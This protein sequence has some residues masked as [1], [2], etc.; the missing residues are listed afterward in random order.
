MIIRPNVKRGFTLIELIV[1]VAIIAVLVAILLPSLGKAREQAKRV[2][3][4]A[5]LRSLALMENIYA[6]TYNN[7]VPRSTDSSFQH[8]FWAYLYAK[9][10]G[11]SVPGDDGIGTATTF[12][13]FYKKLKWLRCPSFPQPSQP[14]CFISNVF[15]ANFQERFYVNVDKVG[16]QGQVVNCIEVCVKMPATAFGT[17]DLWMPGHIDTSPG[18]LQVPQG[19]QGQCRILADLRH[20][21]HVNI[22]FYDAHVETSK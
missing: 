15:Q 6:A 13:K 4:G 22:F 17:Y 20:F 19:G 7:I 2:Q 21:G 18:N 12:E 9:N 5:N 10:S 1:V 8:P 16:N 11:L 3:C 14:L